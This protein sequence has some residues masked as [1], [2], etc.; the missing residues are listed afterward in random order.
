MYSLQALLFYYVDKQHR[1]TMFNY[2]DQCDKAWRNRESNDIII[3]GTLYNNLI[4]L[5]RYRKRAVREYFADA[6]KNGV[7]VQ[8]QMDQLLIDETSVS[9]VI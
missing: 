7:I 9:I 2:N 8:E 3:N 4:K 1:I 5:W 6:D